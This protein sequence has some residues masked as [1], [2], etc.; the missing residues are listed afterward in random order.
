M[1][2]V[3]G[4]LLGALGLW[5]N[6]LHGALNLGSYKHL[7]EIRPHEICLHGMHEKPKAMSGDPTN[8]TEPI[9]CRLKLWANAYGSTSFD[10]ATIWQVFPL[11]TRKKFCFKFPKRP[12]TKM[13]RLRTSCSPWSHAA[14]FFGP[15]WVKQGGRIDR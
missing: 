5:P 4:G 12:I 14:K 8:V 2:M 15:Q 11:S 13:E 3:S 1:V 9:V 7:T 6:A 10:H